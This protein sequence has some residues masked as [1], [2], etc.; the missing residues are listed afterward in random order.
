[1]PS[2]ASEQDGNDVK[3]ICAVDGN[4]ELHGMTVIKLK[5]LVTLS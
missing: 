5:V 2:E 1:M 4:I 3:R